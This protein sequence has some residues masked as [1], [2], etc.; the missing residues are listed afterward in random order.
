MKERKPALT[1]NLKDMICCFSGHLIVN[2]FA[3]IIPPSFNSVD[4][5][6]F[7]NDLGLL[8]DNAVHAVIIDDFTVETEK[9]HIVPER[10]F[11][12]N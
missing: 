10:V 5:H 1:R 6:A 2:D 11:I 7:G 8:V 9:K 4:C 3:L 12:R